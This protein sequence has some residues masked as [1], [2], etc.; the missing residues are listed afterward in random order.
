MK[1]LLLIP[2]LFLFTSCGF[3]QIGEGYRGVYK[4]WGRVEGEPIGPG[5]SFYNPIS[6]TILELEVRE[7]KIEGKTEC[8]TRDTQKVVVDYAITLYPVPNKI[9]VLYSQFGETW[10]ERIVGPELLGSLKDQIGQFIADDL[11]SKRD[12][13]RQMVETELRT[14]LAKRDVVLTSFNLTNLDFDDGY[15]RAVEEKVIAIQKASQAKN[16]TV[17]IEEQAKQKIM[18]AQADA[19]AMQIKSEALKQNKGLVEYEA[20]Q[21]WD[22]ALPTYMF[23]NTVPILN[24]GSIAK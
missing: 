5:L 11:I 16:K 8:F 19:K 24:L 15:E 9:A 1:K 17:E 13:A 23:G 7:K 20:V 2:L 3:N 21:K 22:G 4:R 14:K 6:G 12:H 18:T 10:E